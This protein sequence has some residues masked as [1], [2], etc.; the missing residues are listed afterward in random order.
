MAVGGKDAGLSQYK[1]REYVLKNFSSKNY[2]IFI[3]LYECICV[4]YMLKILLNLNI[5]YINC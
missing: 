4:F 3:L 1:L 5:C 2:I